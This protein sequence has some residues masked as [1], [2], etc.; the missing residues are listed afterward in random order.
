[1]D[2][3]KISR[4]MESAEVFPFTRAEVG[5]ITRDRSAFWPVQAG[6][7]V[8]IYEKPSD[9]ESWTAGERLKYKH[10]NSRVEEHWASHELFFE[11]LE[12][13]IRLR[14]GTDEKPTKY[15]LLD[16]GKILYFADQTSERLFVPE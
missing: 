7:W 8:Q 10:R 13:S 12:K 3:A 6:T 11:G 14:A 1:M 9:S 5:V 16:D 4:L 2:N 15:A